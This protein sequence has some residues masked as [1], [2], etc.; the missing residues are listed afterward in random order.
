MLSA[1]YSCKPVHRSPEEAEMQDECK[2][3][4]QLITELRALRQRF[5][6]SENDI[7]ERKQAD[8]ALKESEERFEA[9]AL[10]AFEGIAFTDSGVVIDANAQ[11]GA[12][13][14]L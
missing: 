2:T 9:L 5:A 11:A 7:T 1:P 3:K 14:P 12:N 6:E 8:E 10:A 4:E 13:A